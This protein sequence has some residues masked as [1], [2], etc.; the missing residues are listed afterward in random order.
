MRAPALDLLH[1]WSPDVLAQAGR[2]T[3]PRDL[4]SAWSWD[5][6]VLVGILLACWWYGRGVRAVWRSAG[7][8]NVVSRGQAAAFG[9]GVA[10]VV[11]ALVSP[12]DPLSEAL[13]SAHMLQHVLLTL[14]AA[15]LLVVSSPL[16]TMAWG[17]PPHLR[18]R[19]GRW[20]GRVRA[21]LWSPALPAV[22]LG[23][24]TAVFTAWHLPV[25][26]NAALDH[27]AVHALE[28]ATMLGSALAFWAPVVRP[29]RTHGGVGVVLLFVS[30][31]ASGI[32]AA[33]MVFAPTTWYAH[34]PTAAWGLTPLEDQQ[35]AG[36]VMWVVGGSLYVIAGAIV[37]M[38]WLRTDEEAT[39]RHDR[40]LDRAPL[41]PPQRM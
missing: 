1:G 9:G 15:P 35:V 40:H 3:G 24:F 23:V 10:T 16:Q 34:P 11:V 25:A 26:Y 32:L 33:L 12:L 18:R 29:R 14:V 36:A 30:L 20:Q 21:L 28:H 17:L 6:L 5:P 19:A 22:G 13:F 38:H 7:H 2:L 27:D 37:L 41:P 31:I 8:G 39:A 4:L